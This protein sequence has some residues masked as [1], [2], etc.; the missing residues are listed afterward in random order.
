MI[1]CKFLRLGQHHID[2]IPM[3]RQNDIIEPIDLMIGSLEQTYDSA[4]EYVVKLKT[5]LKQVAAF[6]RDTLESSQMRQK[7][8]SKLNLM[9]SEI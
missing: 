9:N 7:G 2:P 1:Y 6:S 3:G 4:A 5:I 8:S